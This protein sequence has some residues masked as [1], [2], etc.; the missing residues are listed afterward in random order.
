MD[1]EIVGSV[2]EW[3]TV[4]VGRGYDGLHDLADAE[5]SG[6]VTAGTTW[7]FMLNGRLV[8]I[9]GGSLAAFDGAELTAYEAPSPAL[10][11]L[12]TMQSQDSEKQAEYY[13]NETAISEAD[14]TLADGNFTGYIELSENVLSGNYYVV[15]Y[16]GR[17]MSVAFVGNSR[18]LLT[19][20]EAFERANDEV[21]IYNVYAA[22]I[23][24]IDLPERESSPSTADDPTPDSADDQTLNPVGDE[25]MTPADSTEPDD[26]AATED[27]GL[28]SID[29]PQAGGGDTEPAGD[30]EPEPTTTADSSDDTPATAA[31]TQPDN[32]G[33]S[34]D[35]SAESTEPTDYSGESTEL[36]AP[37]EETGY[38]NTAI[39]TDPATGTADTA[40]T[41]ETA[42]DTASPADT[43]SGDP[44][45][46]NGEPFEEEAEWRNTTTIP[47][48]DPSDDEVA[49]DG[50]QGGG[51][52]QAVTRSESQLSRQQLRERLDKAETVMEK[53]EQRH[54][55]LAAERDE[56]REQRD[57]AQGRIEELEAEL[58]AAQ[59]RIEE[60]EAELAAT[61]TAA[62]STQAADNATQ[63]PQTTRSMTPADALGGTNL[64]VRYDSKGAAT[65][66]DA[67]D[68]E[69][70]PEDIDGNLR[71]DTHTTFDTEGVTVDDTPF[72][73]FL[74]DRIEVAFAEWLVT[75]LL[76]ELRST[77]ATTALKAVYDAIP[78]IDRIELQGMIEL[79]TDEDDEPIERTFDVVVRD[80]R[81]KP[82]F[83]ADFDDSKQPVGADLIEGLIRN[84]NA[85]RERNDSFAAGFGVT[86]SYFTEDAY[87]IADD[88]TG[89]GLFSRSGGK[90]FVNISR[91]QGF[92]LC[93][94]DRIKGG[95]ELQKPEL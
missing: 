58:A 30:E 66:A 53:A 81:G 74:A 15:Y 7:G 79:G 25:S 31:D 59:D 65:L 4:P 49:D 57:A 63:P 39:D 70:T 29:I 1:S 22:D 60:L 50:T 34:I 69:A 26:G 27:S 38:D 94:V 19:D 10:P 43:G 6:G 80:K 90:S 51:G 52:Q 12:Y 72:E 14:T 77:G 2:T 17:S 78:Q 67:H 54:E 47:S 64:F 45:T 55:E 3:E 18:R 35:D 41:G 62:E 8:G 23:D 32:R 40:A 88:A 83:I 36:T 56:A 84:G 89:G 76:F 46:A 95:F 28:G 20:E 44:D 82:L 9:P 33:E 21:G 75:D 42:V 71:I 92:H 73:A 11:L 37:T 86:S 61:D 16:G 91:K 85:L 24:V 87:E 68:G 13:T 93:L 5:F 48:L